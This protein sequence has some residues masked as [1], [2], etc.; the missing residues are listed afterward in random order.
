MNTTARFLGILSLPAAFALTTLPAQADESY[1]GSRASDDKPTGL[2][3]GGHYGR[4]S[5]DSDDFDENNDFYDVVIGG[6]ITPYFG[7]EGG[8]SDFGKLKGDFAE[9]DL[10]GYSLA[11]LIRLPIGNSVGIYA[12][13]GQFW[14]R[15]DINVEALG[16]RYATDIKGN[17]PFY[18]VGM[19]F[20][21]TRNFSVDVEYLRYQVDLS[22]SSLPDAIDDYETEIDTAKVGAKVFF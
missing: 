12:K 4:F 14:W 6:L 10:T 5:N 3:F 9:A 2:Y 16:Q 22:D 1:S 15:S 17:E 18:G 13:G 21:I 19:D 7:I 11:G 8:Y 20:F